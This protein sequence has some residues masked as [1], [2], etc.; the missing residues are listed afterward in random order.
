VSNF[1]EQSSE[2][3]IAEHLSQQNALCDILGIKDYQVNGTRLYRTL[4][5]LWE[6]KDKLSK[7]LKEKY[8]EL[9]GITYDI[10]LYDITSTYFEGEC[11]QNA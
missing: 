9:F 1:C 6:N 11:A 2:L 4:D 8:G 10:L 7:H 5:Q 3:R